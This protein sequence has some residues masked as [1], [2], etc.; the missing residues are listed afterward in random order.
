MARPPP[1]SLLQGC[2][3]LMSYGRALEVV[4]RLPSCRSWSLAS[5]W[6]PSARCCTLNGPAIVTGS[7][8]HRPACVKPD[9]KREGCWIWSEI[10]EIWIFYTLIITS[11]VWEKMWGKCLLKCSDIYISYQLSE[12]YWYSIKCI[13]IQI[14]SRLI[15]IPIP[16]FWN[17]SYT[18]IS[19]IKSSEKQSVIWLQPVD[20]HGLSPLIVTIIH[21]A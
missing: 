13:G 6:P 20:I 3:H 1:S 8:R 18:A 9:T 4:H 7:A 15:K 11:N 19:I 12:Y 14:A 2:D 5:H 16:L 21:F 17:W 10:W